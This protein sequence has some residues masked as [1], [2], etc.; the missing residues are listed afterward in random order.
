MSNLIPFQFD[1]AEVR[2]IQDENGEPWFV[3]KDVCDILGT[4]TRDIRKVLDEDEVDTIH[5]G[6][7]GGRESLI[8]SEPGIYSMILRSRKPDAKR[9]KRWLTHEVLPS[10]RKYGAY[11]T[12]QT[13]EAMMADPQNAIKLFQRLDTEQKK[14][15]V[16][17]FKIEK[18]RPKVLFAESIEVSDTSILIRELAKLIQQATVQP[19]GEKRLFF[20]LREN[21]YIIKKLGT[22]TNSPTQRSMNMGLFEIKES[23]FMTNSHGAKITKTT[24][25]TGKGQIYFINKF[26][27][28]I[29]I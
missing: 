13:I 24:K 8:L 1:T 12:P 11:G 22:D 26:Q 18:D 28:S 29:A 25:V 10:I 27:K 14:R 3:A 17:E 23:T 20:W 2:V 7:H 21:G 4:S 19:M 5:I 16:L 9:F 6:N 15:K